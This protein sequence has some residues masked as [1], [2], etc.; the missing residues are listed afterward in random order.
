MLDANK[1][2]DGLISQEPAYTN[3]INK[4]S[5]R[6]QLVEEIYND[7]LLQQFDLENLRIDYISDQ[8]NS[9]RIKLYEKVMTFINDNYIH[10][11]F[12]NFITE[13]PIR[14]Y[15]FGKILYELFFIDIPTELPD[16]VNKN[17]VDYF[18][19]KT[20]SLKALAIATNSSKLDYK[21]IKYSTAAVLFDCNLENFKIKYF[22]ILISRLE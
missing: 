16:M 2:F 14:S 10:I 9:V 12:N 3:L 5:N 22:N 13:D 8:E 1:Y 21:I 11:D 15:I 18:I 4:I 6:N 20:K 17:I 19:D 7:Y